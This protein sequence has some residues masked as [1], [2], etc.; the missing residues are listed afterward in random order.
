MEMVLRFETRGLEIINYKTFYNSVCH[1]LKT[2]YLGIT[3]IYEKYD[4]VSQQPMYDLGFFVGDKFSV[5]AVGE[6]DGVPEDCQGI[7][8]VWVEINIFSPNQFFEPTKKI[9]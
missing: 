6:G 9:N 3:H 4:D 2:P 7:G 5:V 8:G 1:K